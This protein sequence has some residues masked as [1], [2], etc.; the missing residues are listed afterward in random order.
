MKKR[1]FLIVL[2]SLGIGALPD[3]HLF[4][5]EGANTLGSISS[6]KKFNI[7]NL[8][9]LGLGN[10]DGVDCVPP[11]SYPYATVARLREKSMGKDTTVGHFEIS[12]VKMAKPFFE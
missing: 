9:K 6:S 2:D 7:P 4:G 12:G 1:V 10:I 3:A 11:T 8:I 5:D